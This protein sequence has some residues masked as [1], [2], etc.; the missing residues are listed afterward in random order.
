[1][2]FF[3]Q[4]WPKKLSISII[5]SINVKSLFLSSSKPDFCS[6]VKAVETGPLIFHNKNKFLYRKIYVLVSARSNE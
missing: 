3:N 2:H 5:I 6:K 4:G 1:M